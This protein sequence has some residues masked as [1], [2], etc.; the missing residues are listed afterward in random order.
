MKT[1][2]Q[3]G[4][5]CYSQLK[6]FTFGCAKQ[7]LAC[8]IFCEYAATLK[9][10]FT[11]ISHHFHIE[12][13]WSA[14]IFGGDSTTW[15]L[16]R[17]CLEFYF[18]SGW[19]VVL[20][21]CKLTDSTD[22]LWLGQINCLSVN[23]IPDQALPGWAPL[24]ELDTSYHI[25]QCIIHIRQQL[26]EQHFASLLSLFFQSF[27]LLLGADEP[28]FGE[29]FPQWKVYI[30]AGTQHRKVWF[31]RNVHFMFISNS[32]S[33]TRDGVFL[34]LDNFQGNG[35]GK[36]NCGPAVINSSVVRAQTATSLFCTARFGK[37]RS[38]RLVTLQCPALRD[39]PIHRVLCACM[40]ACARL[41]CL[42]T[43]QDVESRTELTQTVHM[44]NTHPAR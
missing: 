42:T 44:V 10:R 17:I 6:T 14:R 12:A 29:H 7:C 20:L 18:I 2:C 9:F 23:V 26:T 4:T 40:C 15:W 31:M 30:E 1:V 16:I 3:S 34:I 32:I 25:L 43:S 19:C 28:R 5:P 38:F 21:E 36:H 27:L 22:K 24:S 37:S 35:W 41:H 33:A 8:K 11:N 13:S 39:K